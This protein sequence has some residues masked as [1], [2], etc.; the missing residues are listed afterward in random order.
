MEIL[1]LIASAIILALGG[2]AFSFYKKKGE[3]IATKADIDEI[4]NKIEG[5]KSK[6]QVATK[7]EMDFKSDQRQAVLAFYDAVVY[8]YDDVLELSNTNLDCT[9]M[10]EIETYEDKI[11][12]AYRKVVVTARRLELY[13]PEDTDLLKISTKLSSTGLKIVKPTSLFLLTIHEIYTELNEY[14]A[15][16]SSGVNI[17][18]KRLNE[19][20][21]KDEEEWNKIYA[22]KGKVDEEMDDLME[23]YI[24]VATTYLKGG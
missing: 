21:Q 9:R 10:K 6:L 5:I 17:N 1:N 4:T 8:W 15:V 7:S 19:L 3:N 22:A 23:E 24:R 2:M 13:M 11:D 16:A 18:I 14:Y 20:E 12:E